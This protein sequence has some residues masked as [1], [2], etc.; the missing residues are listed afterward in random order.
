MNVVDH[1]GDLKSVDLWGSAL[2]RPEGDCE[3]LS[4]S[5]HGQEEVTTKLES[6]GHK[7]GDAQKDEDEVEESKCER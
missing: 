7:V 4:H 1:L 5:L 3:H 6:R 2:A